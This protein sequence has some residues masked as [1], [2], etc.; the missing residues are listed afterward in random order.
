VLLGFYGA[1]DGNFAPPSGVVDMTLS[2]SVSGGAFVQIYQGPPLPYW[3][4]VGDGPSFSSEPLDAT[5]PYEWQAIDST[6]TTE[7]GPVTP[8]GFIVTVPDALTTLIIRL[9][10]AATNN[11]PRPSGVTVS[12][13]Q[14]TTK[15]PAAGFAAMPF[16]VVNLELF[17]DRDTAIGQDVMNPDA[18]N[19]WTLPGWSR[20]VWRISVISPSADERDFYRDT[21]LIAFRAL[22]AVLFSRI[23][24]NIR[25]D[26]QAT[27]GTTGD[28]WTG[29]APGFYWAD[30]MLTLEGDF[31]VTML[32][33]FGLIEHINVAV[34]SSG[35]N[36]V[37]EIQIPTTA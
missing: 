36:V 22:K 25:H 37:D 6:G 20:R 17:Q 34:S 23:A 3:C 21:V 7:I 5:L 4:D 24:Q 10:Q 11:A 32:T 14:V 9:L 13:V 18:Q 33:G 35:G 15:M 12:P 19:L 16:I 27:S 29:Q 2:R 26:F 8:A 1:D 31:S 28:E 30:A